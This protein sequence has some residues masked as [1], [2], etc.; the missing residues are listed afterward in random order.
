MS[1]IK[2]STNLESIANSDVVVEAVFEEMNLK[3]EMFI[4]IDKLAKENSILATNTSTLDID[5]IA[6]STSRPQFVIGTHFFSPANVM[7]LLE[8]VRGIQTKTDVL[9]TL[10]QLSKKIAKVGIIAGNCDGFVGNRMFHA[11]ITQAH[12]LVEEGATPE[13]VDQVAE[14]WGWAMGPFAVNDLAGNDVGWRIRKGKG[15]DYYKI[16]VG[17]K[18][19]TNI[20]PTNLYL[21]N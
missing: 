8:I 19:V 18:G 13:Q 21:F 20:I 11:Y 1:L 9:A 3:K 10:M 6:E 7:R 12:L 14:T 15:E 16:V 4:K 17:E 2:G 5:Q